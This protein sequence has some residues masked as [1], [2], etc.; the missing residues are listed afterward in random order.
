MAWTRR[1]VTGCEVVGELLDDFGIEQRIAA[2]RALQPFAHEGL[3]VH[4][5]MRG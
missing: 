4:G 3:E 2:R 5:V 1:L